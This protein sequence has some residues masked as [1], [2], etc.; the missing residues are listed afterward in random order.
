MVSFLGDL[1]RQLAGGADDERGDA[2]ALRARGAVDALDGGQQEG[3]G[4]ARARLR[5]GK[6]VVS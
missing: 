4:L 2:A 3:Q 6:H 5:L 1:L